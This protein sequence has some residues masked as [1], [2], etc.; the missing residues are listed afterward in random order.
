MFQAKMD[1]YTAM[2]V[3]SDEI[4]ERMRKLGAAPSDIVRHLHFA[5]NS[6]MLQDA[7]QRRRSR[8]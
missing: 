5:A 1:I 2:F 8:Q 3:V 6:V 4:V 7:A